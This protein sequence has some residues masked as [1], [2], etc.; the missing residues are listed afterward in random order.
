VTVSEIGTVFRAPRYQ[1]IIGLAFSLLILMVSGFAAV[2]L[3]ATGDYGVGVF[4]LVW[5]AAGGWFTFHIG[6]RNAQRLELSDASLR[7]RAAFR[8]GEVPIGQ[9]REVNQVG[10]RRNSSW[11]LEL[12]DGRSIYVAN[13]RDVG[14]FLGKVVSASRG[15]GAWVG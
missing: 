3:L 13:S 1:L 2:A 9:V 7:W 6:C 10:Q 12:V 4:M 15:E 11:K 14:P 5:A 8:R